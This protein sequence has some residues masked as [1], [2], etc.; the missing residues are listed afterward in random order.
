MYAFKLPD[1]GEGIQEGELLAW[2]VN[3]GDAISEDEPLCDIE[4][5]KAA[6]TIP[7][8]KTGTVHRLGARVGDTVQVGQVLVE[9]ETID[10]ADHPPTETSPDSDRVLSQDPPADEG[11]SSKTDPDRNDR[12]AGGKPGNT[13]DAKR[14]SR[15]IAAPAV[16]R[17]AREREI[18][19]NQVSGTGP[20]GRVTAE[21]LERH[22]K[23][24]EGADSQGSPVTQDQKTSLS[25]DKDPDK[26]LDTASTV[27]EPLQVPGIPFLV[28]SP[29]PDFEAQGPVET[30]P[31]R[32]LRRKTAAKTVTASILV[33][34]VAHMDEADV[35]ELETLRQTFNNHPER[36]LITGD[37]SGT[38]PA[39][40]A[41]LTLLPFVV[42]ALSH[43][44]KSYPAFNASVDTDRM[45]IIHKQFYHIGFAAD[46]PKGLMVPVIRD[47]DRLSPS[48]LGDRIRDL[49]Q[50]AREGSISLEDLTGGTFT[51]T[52][53]GAIGGTHVLPIINF[54]ETA[55]LG[56][57]RVEKKP[58][59]RNEAI[60]IRQM[61]PMT[62]CFDHRAADGVRAARFMRDLKAMLEDPVVFLTHT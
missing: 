22:E 35:T 8:P 54:P 32:S 10:A 27:D 21:D 33:P 19:I 12:A 34:H 41:N 42:K 17:L 14:L 36:R 52:N 16:R 9:I 50:A 53:V 3:Q 25:R 44:L 40:T 1:L 45:Q 61:L 59:V 58:V 2:H 15:A 49:A 60:V 6:V 13:G 43:L 29:L 38:D 46:T 20:G 4:T 7:S 55:I 48:A 5:D 28:S 11:K 30:V 37:E 47:A 31:I 23:Q 18:D 57:G 56:L 62:L 24:A 51:V 26:A 39:T